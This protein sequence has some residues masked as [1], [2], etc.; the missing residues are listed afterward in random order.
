MNKDLIPSLLVLYF[1]AKDLHYAYLAVGR[2][3]DHAFMDRYTDGIMDFIDSIQ[4]VANRAVYSDYMSGADILRIASERMSKF[5][6]NASIDEQE[7]ELSEIIAEC[8]DLCDKYAREQ[9]RATG[10][11]NVLNG[12]SEKLQQLYGFQPNNSN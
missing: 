12:I 2:K 5:K 4:E 1:K 7:R 10:T 8:L 9:N 6:Q 3:G 11:V